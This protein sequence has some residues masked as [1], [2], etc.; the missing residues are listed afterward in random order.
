MIQ[1][2]YSRTLEV[3]V[4]AKTCVLFSLSFKFFI[5]VKVSF[6]FI[7]LYIN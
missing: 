6:D 1:L 7:F 5:F 2:Q 4:E 3:G